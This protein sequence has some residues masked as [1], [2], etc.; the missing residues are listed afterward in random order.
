METFART[1]SDN[2]HNAA[3]RLG[4]KITKTDG[5]SNN[6]C[7]RLY[8]YASQLSVSTLV[9]SKCYRPSRI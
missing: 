6:G 5:L 2:H 3:T 7:L 4:S 1:I 8:V 9:E